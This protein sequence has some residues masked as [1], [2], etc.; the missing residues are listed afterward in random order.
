VLRPILEESGL[1]AGEDFSLAFS[2]ETV[3]PG[4][5]LTELRENDRHVGYVGE[6]IPAEIIALYESFV[7]G[8]IHTT[9]ATTAEFVKL[10]Q[11]AYRDTNIAFANETAKLAYEHEIDSREAI[12][13]AN[14][15]PRV[16]ILS[17]GPGVGGHCLP[18]DPLFL[19][20][21]DNGRAEFIETARDVNDSMPSFVTE[22]LLDALGS[23]EGS[24]IAVLGVAYKGGVDDTRHSPGLALIEHL[25]GAGNGI[26]V[27]ASDPRVENA[28][29][30]L[31]PLETAVD[32]ADAIVLVTDHP[33]Y[34][35][36][37][38]E[39]IGAAMAQR[40][41]VDTRAMLDRDRWEAAGFTVRRV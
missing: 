6:D 33:E 5:I 27:A 3:L 7:E 18:I 31:V 32:G 23:I 36:L 15:H 2:P 26:S 35:D 22:L 14:D 9:D 17:P 19:N 10:I 37:N 12:Q 29:V 41:L 24:Q 21:N 8:E 11:N 28:M 30:P 20:Q 39:H 34:E 1:I 4:N 40:L 13:L 25:S 16:D 38:P